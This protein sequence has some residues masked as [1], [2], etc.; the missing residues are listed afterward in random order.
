MS[1][2]P[3]TP[4]SFN[5]RYLGDSYIP[6][7][8]VRWGSLFFLN[9]LHVFDLASHVCFWIEIKIGNSQRWWSMARIPFV[10]WIKEQKHWNTQFG[11]VQMLSN[12]QEEFKWGRNLA[13]PR[14]AASQSFIVVYFLLV[15]LSCGWKQSD[16]CRAAQKKLKLPQR[17]GE[18]TRKKSV[19]WL[20]DWLSFCLWVHFCS[21]H[22]QKEN[23]EEEDDLLLA[24]PVQIEQQD[25]FP[26]LFA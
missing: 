2:Q 9:L 14:Q 3:W 15:F 11:N 25:L 21:L 23:L 1:D 4:T 10:I 5:L 7:S 6:L 19:D 22:N 16:C 12:K 17:R 8:T 18:T 26:Q 20:T 24:N 13:S